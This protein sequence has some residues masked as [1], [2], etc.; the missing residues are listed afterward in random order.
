MSHERREVEPEPEHPDDVCF[1]CEAPIVG[2]GVYVQDT[3]SGNLL[4]SH[5]I[6]SVCACK[7]SS[8]GSF[9]S[10]LKGGSRA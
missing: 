10:V 1:D 7:G 4:G 5:W 2:K 6:C 9:G 3:L 8:D